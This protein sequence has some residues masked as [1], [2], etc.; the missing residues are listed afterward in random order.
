[1]T[2]KGLAVSLSV[3]KVLLRKDASKEEVLRKSATDDTRWSFGK[4]VFEEEARTIFQPD[5]AQ[6]GCRKASMYCGSA[7][8]G[9]Y[10][11]TV[12]RRRIIESDAVGRTRSSY[13]SIGFFVEVLFRKRRDRAF[14][15]GVRV[16]YLELSA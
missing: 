5:R 1:M 11:Y 2:Q 10:M 12:V 4:C 13:Y 14:C 3:R 16:R 15:D 7:A 9:E 6:G 8:K